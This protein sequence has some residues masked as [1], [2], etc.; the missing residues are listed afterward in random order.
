MFCLAFLSLLRG[1]FFAIDPYG[2]RAIMNHSL[3]LII[4]GF[5]YPLLSGVL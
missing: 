4:L 3:E 5:G 1:I 2:A